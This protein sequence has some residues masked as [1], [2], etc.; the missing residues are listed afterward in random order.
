MDFDE[1]LMT[2]MVQVNA[3]FTNCFRDVRLAADG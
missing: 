2:E 3:S 1:F